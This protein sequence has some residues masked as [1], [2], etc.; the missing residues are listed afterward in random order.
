MGKKNYLIEGI[1]GAGKTS[2]AEAL[3]RSGHHVIH[4]DRTLAYYGDPQTGAALVPP[5]D[6]TGLEAIEWAYA[7]WI[8]PVDRVRA[9]IADD[10]TAA[11]FFCG[12][13]KNA[14]LFID[15]F[16][17][18]FILDL[19]ART[20]QQRLVARP[21]DEFGGKPAERDFLLR[22][23]AS[24]IDRTG[25]GFII[26]ATQPVDDVVDAILARCGML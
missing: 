8:W 1:S 22:R 26:D 16:D 23:H 19:D 11:T 25:S 9:L 4:G 6:L 10:S 20:L 5:P 17:A 7:R 15:L 24:G 2:V 18:A 13:A 14:H 12:G 21:P 3:E